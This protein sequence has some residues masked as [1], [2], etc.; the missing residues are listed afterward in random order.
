MFY[1]LKMT[2]LS[3]Y[4]ENLTTS[5]RLRWYQ[6][7]RI[8]DL[9][10]TFIFRQVSVK[11]VAAVM[12]RITDYHLST[13]LR[14]FDVNRGETRENWFSHLARLNFTLNYTDLN[15]WYCSSS[16]F[17]PHESSF[18]SPINET[19]YLSRLD[20]KLNLLI[21]HQ[22]L[23]QYYSKIIRKF[24]FGIDFRFWFRSVRGK[25]VKVGGEGENFAR[26]V[27]DTSAV[28]RCELD[29]LSS[30]QTRCAEFTAH[31]ALVCA[32]DITIAISRT[33]CFSLPGKVTCAA[34]IFI[35][36]DYYSVILILCAIFRHLE[37]LGK[38]FMSTWIT[39]NKRRIMEVVWP[40]VN[41]I[42]R[43]ILSVLLT[44][45]YS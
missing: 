16:H 11:F 7:A 15:H 4:D 33:F 42:D 2:V 9:K 39:V 45:W 28:A 25:N 12:C 27:D 20:Q 38:K 3:V 6:N 23:F 14:S 21:E 44:S 18:R 41:M 26:V 1:Q 29:R 35:Y 36:V 22:L 30:R 17:R 10:I 31:R 19:R 34:W 43:C 32:R 5:K 40:R 8:F 24:S 13:Y 37:G